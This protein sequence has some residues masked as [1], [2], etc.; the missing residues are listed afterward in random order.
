MYNKERKQMYIEEKMAETIVS[1]YFLKNAFLKTEPFETELDKDLCDFN[2]E[3]IVNLLKAISF[4]SFD[5]VIVFNSTLNLYTDWCMQKHMIKDNQNHFIEL[6]R[7]NLA[8]CVNALV[9]EMQYVSRET[10]IEWGTKLPNIA[11]AFIILALYEGIRG[12]SFDEILKARLSDFDVEN[13]IYHAPTR[14]IKITPYLIKLAQETEKEKIYT[15]ISSERI[16]QYNLIDDDFI[17][18]S[19]ENAKYEDGFHKQVRMTMRIARI[20]DYLGVL[21]WMN[22]NALVMSGVINMIKTESSKLGITPEDYINNKNLIN[23]VEKQ[24]NKKIYPIKVGFIQK[25]K[26]VLA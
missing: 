2:A 8:D 16:R 14:D 17:I 13:N 18:K 9:V 23:N 19:I 24:Y 22:A 26:D 25:Y 3:E 15:S 10:V 1:P 5:S 21:Q 20:F 4:P 12:K 7:Q 11:D 6:T